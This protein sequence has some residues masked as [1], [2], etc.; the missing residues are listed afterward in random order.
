MGP[1]V[2]CLV[3]LFWVDYV[4]A[5]DFTGVCDDGCVVSVDEADDLGTSVTAAHTKVFE[6][7]AVA[8]GD[9]AC[10]A[11]DVVSDLP[12]LGGVR[13]GGCGFRDE[14]VRECWRSSCDR[15]VGANL[16]VEDGECIESGL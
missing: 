10:S 13:P 12:H 11:D 4:F 1:G 6:C 5:E 8:E 7:A 16:V 2:F 14:G 15:A 3:V 9:R